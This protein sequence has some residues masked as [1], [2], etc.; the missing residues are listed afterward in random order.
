V[1]V[2]PTG[3][4]RYHVV[5]SVDT[6]RGAAVRELEAANCALATDVAALLVAI[7]LYPERSEELEARAHPKPTV[8][9]VVPEKH[10]VPTERPKRFTVAATLLTD[11]TSMPSVAGGGGGTFGF[12]A[13]E[14]ISLETTVGAYATQTVKLSDVRSAEFGMQSAA[15]RGCFVPWSSGVFAAC[16]GA[17][18]IRLAGTG[19]GVETPHDVTA[20]YVG[21][22]AGVVAR[23]PAGRSVAVR[24]SAEAFVP[25]VA[26]RFL[27]DGAEVHQPGAVGIV[28]QLGPE[29]SF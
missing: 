23:L 29:V 15:V 7:S 17:I 25:L 18:G 10:E 14:R 3:D 9:A 5:V 2:E 12:R 1:R 22:S 11:L 16:A 21:T 24:I 4:G 8:D 26:H 6:T 27:L 19:R 20:L 13:T 28:G